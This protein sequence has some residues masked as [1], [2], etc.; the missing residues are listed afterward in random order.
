MSRALLF[1]AGCGLIVAGVALVVPWVAFIVAGLLVCSLA[2]LWER[3][4][5]RREA[6]TTGEGS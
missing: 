3:A 1:L 2:A 4:A 6:T 5:M